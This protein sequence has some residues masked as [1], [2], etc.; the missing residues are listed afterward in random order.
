MNTYIQQFARAVAERF[1]VV[2]ESHQGRV[3]LQC[4][5]N[6]GQLVTTRVF[7]DRQLR[8]GALVCM[9]L[10]DLRLSLYKQDDHPP[11][12]PLPETHHPRAS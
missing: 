10:A 6:A 9:V 7:S 5:D 2:I 11:L 4:L 12:I 1:T 8:N 3:R